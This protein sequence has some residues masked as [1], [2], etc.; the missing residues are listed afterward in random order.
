MPVRIYNPTYD[1]LTIQTGYDNLVGGLTLLVQAQTFTE[2]LLL[3]RGGANT[4]IGGYNCDYSSNNGFSTI[5]GNITVAGAGTL[6]AIE[7]II[8]Q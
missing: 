4:I 7:K 3:N 5:K 8:I 2:N 1:F 6:I